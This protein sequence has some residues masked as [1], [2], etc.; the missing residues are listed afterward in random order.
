M[1]RKQTAASPVDRRSSGAAPCADP[2]QPH[3]IALFGQDSLLIDT[4]VLQT[5]SDRFH[6]WLVNMSDIVRDFRVE[7]LMA[8]NAN[9]AALLARPSDKTLKLRVTKASFWVGLLY[10]LE[11]LQS[12]FTRM[13]LSD[14]MNAAEIFEVESIITFPLDTNRNEVM[15]EVEVIRASFPFPFLASAWE[16]TWNHIKISNIEPIAI[17]ELKRVTVHKIPGQWIREDR[18]GDST[19]AVTRLLTHRSEQCNVCRRSCGVPF[20]RCWYCGE[21]PSYHHGRCCPSLQQQPP[22]S[23]SSSRRPVA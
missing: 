9:L 17:L 4:D 20:A 22:S 2:V 13:L 15:T 3:R 14:Q 23:S 19:F 16:I 8:W 1:G 12:S 6:R 18:N 21:S 11:L 5:P 7:E 10:E